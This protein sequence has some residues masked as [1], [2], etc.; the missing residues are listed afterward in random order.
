[1]DFIGHNVNVFKEKYSAIISRVCNK[2]DIRRPLRCKAVWLSKRDQMGNP[3]PCNKF[4]DGTGYYCKHHTERKY[5][6]HDE[7]HLINQLREFRKNKGIM[8]KHRPILM[9]K[10]QHSLDNGLTPEQEEAWVAIEEE[11]LRLLFEERYQLIPKGQTRDY[12]HNIWMYG[13][14]DR[15]TPYFYMQEGSNYIIQR[16]LEEAKQILE[17]QKGTYQDPAIRNEVE[18][19]YGTWSQ[20]SKDTTEEQEGDRKI[21]ENDLLQTEEQK[22]PYDL[23][24]SSDEI[25][26][27]VANAAG[28]NERW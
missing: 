26:E 15:Y 28:E 16:P 23:T 20:N 27:E 11:E 9:R 22:V 12:N 24:K 3:K 5:W 1:M 18:P 25:M 14:K 13:L 21:I 17:K 7:Y 6:D 2:F 10:L 4:R 19:N 8:H